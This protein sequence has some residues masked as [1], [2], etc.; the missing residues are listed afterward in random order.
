[1]LPGGEDLGV[2][3]H[4]TGAPLSVSKADAALE[5]LEDLLACELLLANDVLGLAP[6][7]PALG[8]GTAAARRVVE[9]AIAAADPRPDA[10]H[11]ALRRLFPG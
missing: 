11:R 9:H 3:D 2:E 7:R 6:D 5:L 8:S 1:V 4:G 10:V